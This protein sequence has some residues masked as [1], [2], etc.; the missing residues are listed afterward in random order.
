MLYFS[1]T[2]RYDL[3]KLSS[4]QR[5]ILQDDEGCFWEFWRL[6]HIFICMMVD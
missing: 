6:L 3:S 5:V 2:Q 1:L 4:F